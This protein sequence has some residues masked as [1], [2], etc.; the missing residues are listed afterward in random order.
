MQDQDILSAYEAVEVLE[1][2]HVVFPKLV[3]QGIRII[4]VLLLM[5]VQYK[6]ERR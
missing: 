5:L 3:S 2:T 1:P 4:I 6:V